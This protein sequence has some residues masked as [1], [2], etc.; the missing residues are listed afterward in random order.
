MNDN[1]L[2]QAAV[3]NAATEQFRGLLETH[4]KQIAK[5]A[6]AGNVSLSQQ[7]DTLRAENAAA[8][9]AIAQNTSATARTLDRWDGDGQPEVRDVA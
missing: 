4:F 6:Q 5:A 2:K 8:L 3:I 7:L 1:D 9:L